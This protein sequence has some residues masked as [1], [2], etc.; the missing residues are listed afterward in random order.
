MSVG[1]IADANPQFQD[2]KSRIKAGWLNWKD[3]ARPAGV[4]CYVIMQRNLKGKMYITMIRPVLMYG[5]EAW[6]VSIT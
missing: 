4:L 5:A 1:L 3:P 2:A 6:T